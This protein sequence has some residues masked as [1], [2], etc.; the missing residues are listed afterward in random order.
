M[1]EVVQ[2]GAALTER[3]DTE[4]KSCLMFNEDSNSNII[5]DLNKVLEVDQTLDQ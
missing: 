3:Y 1:T 5:A 4:S 2:D